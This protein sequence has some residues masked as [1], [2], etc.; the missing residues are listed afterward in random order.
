MKCSA[1]IQRKWIY[2]FSFV[3]N[4]TLFRLQYV[5]LYIKHMPVL[6]ALCYTIQQH[7]NTPCHLVMS[8]ACWILA[9]STCAAGLFANQVY[10]RCG[11]GVSKHISTGDVIS[12]SW[13][14]HCHHIQICSIILIQ[15]LW[16]TNCTHLKKIND[17]VEVA[18]F[19]YYSAVGLLIYEFQG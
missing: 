18:N 10:L 1:F 4:I 8:V 15:L 12:H 3:Q 16:Q 7:N 6:F 9:K 19:K 2:K 13:Q 14:H 17:Q 11:H 5:N